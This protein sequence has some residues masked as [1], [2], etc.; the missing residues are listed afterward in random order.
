MKEMELLRE[1]AQETPLPAPAEL[2]AARARLVAAIS[3]PATRTAVMAEVTTVQPDGFSQRL[4]ARR[5]A[6]LLGFLTSSFPR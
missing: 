6:D 5:L 1:P 4:Q 3:D 2:D